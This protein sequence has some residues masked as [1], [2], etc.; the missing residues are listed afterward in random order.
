[1]LLAPL[2]F[3]EPERLVE[4]TERWPNRPGPRPISTLNYRDWAN[5]STVFEQMAAVSW[6]SVTVSDGSE[7]VYVD[8]SL[9]SPSYFELFGLHAA[10]GRT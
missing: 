9:V 4:L 2:P 8:G 6:G 5:Q 3:R 7:P 10:I 1:V